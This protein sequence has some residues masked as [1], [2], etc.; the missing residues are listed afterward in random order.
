MQT[1]GEEYCCSL[2]QLNDFYVEIKYQSEVNAITKSSTFSSYSML[3]PYLLLND[4]NLAE[5]QI[6]DL[7]SCI[8]IYHLK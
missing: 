2:Y 7:I 5:I 4:C 1:F 6:H 3:E 8:F